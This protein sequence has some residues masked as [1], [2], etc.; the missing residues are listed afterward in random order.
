MRKLEADLQHLLGEGEG[1]GDV[2]E[3]EVGGHGGVVGRL[4]A[5]AVRI[6]ERA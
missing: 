2:R 3:G 5:A 1:V 4:G 6:P